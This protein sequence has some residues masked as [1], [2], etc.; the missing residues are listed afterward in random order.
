MDFTESLP[1][2]CPYYSIQPAIVNICIVFYW[3]NFKVNDHIMI[4]SLGD[5][6]GVI[7][8]IGQQSET[9]DEIIGIELHD[10]HLI[11]P[12]CTTNEQLFV[13]KRST[14]FFIKRYL[15]IMD[16]VEDKI[17]AGSYAVLKGLNRYNKLNGRTVRT[18][19]IVNYL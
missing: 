10:S 2:I 15:S 17:S 4:K 18:V 19:K 6:P 14:S 13:S 7:R 16:M 1:L 3:I 8:Y 5:K 9:D 12:N 11:K